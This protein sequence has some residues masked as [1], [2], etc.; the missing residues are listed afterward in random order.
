[1]KI[2]HVLSQRPEATGSG[3]FIQAMLREAAR[4]GHENCLVAG[5][6]DDQPPDPDL[7]S[8]A[9]YHYVRF[10][11]GGL[12]FPVVGM[13][14][15]MPYDSTRFCDL[16]AD[17]ITAYEKAFEAVLTRVVPEFQPDIIHSNHLWIVTA[18]VRRLYPE[19]PVVALCHGSDL[20]QF[21]NCPHLADRVRPACA[22]LSAILA[23]SREQ[24]E[25][26]VNVYQVDPG[27]V[28]IVGAGYNEAVFLPAAKPKSPVVLAYA[29]KL[30]RAK[31]VPWFLRALSGL[32]SKNWYL[33]LVGGG[34]GT[35]KAECLELA[36]KLGKERVAVHGP[37]PQ[38][39]LADIFQQAHI[40]VLPSLF[41]GLPL[42]LL[43]ALACG[44]R[45]VTT[46]LPGVREVLG[47]VTAEWVER[48]DL[49]RLENVDSPVAADEANFE[50]KLQR[51]LYA[52]IRRAGEDPEP[53]PTPLRPLLEAFTWK[54]VFEKVE[55]VYHHCIG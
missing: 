43:E 26:I 36:E 49:P 1:M 11:T 47:E 42:V 16:D 34:S 33:H 12:P 24:K 5:I 45:L 6:P 19:V 7:L 30:S 38:A 23:L 32:Q 21:S 13:S 52:Q 8:D 39:E 40:F 35:E 25:Q 20:R 3:I 31:G 46:D 4:K 53:D 50:H 15:V 14:D 41:E 48:V 9:T 44:C 28:Y 54:G 29:G 18:L 37:M 55:K 51:A 10:G 2:L 17:G 27:R 22:G